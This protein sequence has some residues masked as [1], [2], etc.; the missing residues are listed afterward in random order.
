MMKPDD[1][2]RLRELCAIA[3]NASGPHLMAEMAQAIGRVMNSTTARIGPDI[4]TDCGCTVPILHEGASFGHLGIGSLSETFTDSDRERLE[5]LARLV[6]WLL[7]QRNTLDQQLQESR[8]A[9]ERLGEQTQILDQIHESVITMDLAGYITG[10]NKGAANLFGY[11]EEEAVGKHILFLYA[12]PDADDEGFQDAFLEHGGRELEVRRRRKSGEVFWASL[13][14]SLMRDEEGQ[15]SGLIGYL[16]DITQRVEAEKTMRLQSRI[17]EHSEESILITD[18]NKR[19]LSVN[20]AFCKITGYSYTEVLGKTPGVLRSDRHP[21]DF[22]EAIW[23][24]VEQD[25]S[26]H[27]EVWSRRKGGDDYPSWASISLVRNPEGQVSHYFSIFTDITERKSAEERIHYLAYYDN[28]T[29]LPNRSLFYKLVDQ[30]LVEAKRNRLHGAILFVDLNRFKPINDTLGHGIGDRLLVQVAERLRSAVRNED[31]VARLGGDEFVVALFDIA[32]REHAAIVGQ[33]LLNAL[34]PAFWV[35]EHELQVGAAIGISVYPRDGFDTESLLRMADIAMYR[36]KHSGQDGYAFYSH[37]MNQRALDRL[38]IETGLRHGIE[39]DEL[40]LHYQPK[41]DIESGRIVGAEALVRW[42]HPER[43]MVPPGEF[44]PIAEES[45]LVIRLSAWVLEA[46]L[47]QA[48]VWHASGLPQIKVAVNLSARDFSPGLAERIESMLASHGVPPD[49]LELEITEGMLTHSSDDVISMM[50]K[51]SAFGVM[52]SL[53]D[54]G[55][56]YSSLS[57]LKRFP[58]DTLKIDQSFVRGIPQ[59]GNDCAIAGAIVSMAQRL[60]HRV[61]AEGVETMEQL[62]F[63]RSLGC[64]EIQG[65]LFSPPVPAEKLEA[66]VRE[67]RTLKQA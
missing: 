60:G 43:G 50:D 57:Y 29:G 25:G 58:I 40:L 11:S 13:Q 54:F 62:A 34:E 21:N 42:R 33:K 61:I 1:F 16:S 38:K 24:H 3:L 48:R 53:D 5:A 67:G 7:H 20:P 4:S 37:E 65:Y 2:D 8:R 36:A 46:A 22:Y 47:R 56:G 49:W 31:V 27:G 59:D 32:R 44:I 9:A 28:L 30:A 66:M 23:T 15:P 51:L 14:L 63:L 45:G 18:A 55:T 10:W 6:G 41:V 26:W 39:H 52:L 12:D 17:F 35:D 19:I 64:Q